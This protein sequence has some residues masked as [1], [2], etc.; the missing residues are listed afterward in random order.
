MVSAFADR[1]AVIDVD[2]TLGR[3]S[4][5]VVSATGARQFTIDVTGSVSF[6]SFVPRDRGLLFVQMSADDVLGTTSELRHLSFVTGKVT[7]LAWWRSSTLALNRYPV[8]L[9]SNAY[10]GDAKGCYIVVA[11]DQEQTRSRLAAVPD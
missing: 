6:A 7:K 4:I 10:P 3:G 5:N 11:S 2:H 9:S 8:G 1:V